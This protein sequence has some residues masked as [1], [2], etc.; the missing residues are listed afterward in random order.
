MA[1]VPPDGFDAGSPY[2][3]EPNSSL[4]KTL[5]VLNIVFAC[6]LMLCGLCAGANVGMQAVMGPMMAAQREQLTQTLQAEH[7]A[8]LKKLQD[9]IDATDDEEEKSALQAKLKKE[10]AMPVP[11]IPD[12][13]KM[14]ASPVMKTYML[15]DAVTGVLL[16]LLMLASG[17][18]LLALK[19]WGRSLALWVAGLKIIRLVALY[20]YCALVVAPEWAQQVRRV[21]DEINK[22]VP[23]GGKTISPQEMNQMTTVMGAMMTGTCIA[24]IVLGAIYPLVLLVA[25]TRRRVKAAFAAPILDVRPDDGYGR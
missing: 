24:M 6:V 19:E 7:Q 12:T 5:G 20:G 3:V 8:K 15:A 22:S 25:L 21:F 14:V 2:P 1:S 4:P 23:Q 11:T 17:I 16:N 18:G 13:T 9:D 10:Q